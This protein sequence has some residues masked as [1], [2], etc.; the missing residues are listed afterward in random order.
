[1]SNDPD[2]IRALLSRPFQVVAGKGGVGRTMLASAIALRSAQQGARTLLLE[3]NAPDNAAR[4]LGV[5]PSPDEPRQVLPNLWLCRMTPAGAMREY[6]L[7][8]LKF[9]A[10]YSLV[11]EN[12]LVKYLLRSV[13]SLAE[14]TMSGKAWYHSTETLKN[15]EPKYQ[16][17]IIDAPATG[18]ALTLLTV[19]RVVA[20]TVPAGVMRNAAEKMAQLIESK[21]HSCLHVVALPEEMPVNEGLDLVKAGRA[22]LRMAMGLAIMNRVH[23]PLIDAADVP[24]LDRISG[25]EAEPYVAA[26]R[27]HL[28]L[29]ALQAEHT[30]RFETASGM[31]LV[32][33]PELRVERAA[34]KEDNG[35]PI[36]DRIVAELDRHAGSVPVARAADG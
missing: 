5:P 7:L 2:T 33:I 16:R 32:V 27:R 28:A 30:Q 23:P 31:P 24:V 18:H 29:E 14:F 22:R 35:R 20:D 8:V 15:G 21:D 6:A 1:M 12:R 26:A 13:P 17:I 4:A 10:L 11:F 19:S 9:K 36:V 3:V 25:A 34:S